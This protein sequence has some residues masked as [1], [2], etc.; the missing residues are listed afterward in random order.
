MG[1]NRISMDGCTGPGALWLD[2]RDVVDL[3]VVRC[4]PEKDNP[5]MVIMAQTIGAPKPLEDLD[6]IARRTT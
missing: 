5:R 4:A 6:W 3:R 2:D 1:D